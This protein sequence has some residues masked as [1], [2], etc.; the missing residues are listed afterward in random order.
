MLVDSPK[1]NRK[2]KR[3]ETDRLDQAGSRCNR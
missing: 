1:Q 3:V 2:C